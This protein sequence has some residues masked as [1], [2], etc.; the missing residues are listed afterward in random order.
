MPGSYGVQCNAKLERIRPATKNIHSPRKSRQSVNVVPSTLTYSVSSGEGHEGTW[1][2][3]SACKEQLR[4][5]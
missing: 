4:C 1:S 5:H 3:G 2:S